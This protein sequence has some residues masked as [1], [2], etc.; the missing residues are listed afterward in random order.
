MQLLKAILS[1]LRIDSNANSCQVGHA[2][3]G[4]FVLTMVRTV[5][6]HMI[7]TVL[8]QLLLFQCRS[9]V[10]IVRT[11][12]SLYKPLN[13]CTQLAICNWKRTASCKCNLLYSLGREILSQ[14]NL[15]TNFGSVFWIYIYIFIYIPKKTFDKSDPP[16]TNWKTHHCQSFLLLLLLLFC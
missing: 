1:N 8:H 11:E 13:H 7:C 5:Q 6:W 4:V 3:K 12:L 14:I 15:E 16:K 10:R 2:E 9:I